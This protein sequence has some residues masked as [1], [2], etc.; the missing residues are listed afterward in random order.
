MIINGSDILKEDYDLAIKMIKENLNEFNEYLKVNHKLAAV[1][2][3]KELTF[4]G[5]KDSKTIIDLFFEDKLFPKIKEERLKKLE[6]LAKRPLIE[7]IV[8][9]FK[10]NK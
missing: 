1:K 10:K 3:L 8:I 4:L 9:K 7:E 6:Q 5:L 2:R